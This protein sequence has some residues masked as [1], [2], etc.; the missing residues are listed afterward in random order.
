MKTF[1]FQHPKGGGTLRICKKG[2]CSAGGNFARIKIL[3]NQKILK[4]VQECPVK[5]LWLKSKIAQLSPIPTYG[6]YLWSPRSFLWSPR[7]QFHPC[8]CSHQSHF[9]VTKVFSLVA[10]GCLWSP[11]SSLWSPRSF[12]PSPRLGQQGLNLGHF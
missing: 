6:P 2:F 5:C 3:Q 1:F 12:P 10:N 11:R 7:C 9:L 8:A 4:Y